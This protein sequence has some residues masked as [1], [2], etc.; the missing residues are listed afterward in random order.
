M[1][2]NRR[3]RAPFL[4]QQIKKLIQQIR[5]RSFIFRPR[6]QN[7]IH[8]QSLVPAASANKHSAPVA[9]DGSE[10][11]V[12][13]GQAT[14]NVILHP[15]ALFSILESFEHLPRSAFMGP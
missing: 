5:P 14:A 2:V 1:S 4:E 6:R 15:L 3:N 12:P 8:C 7:A 13:S 10:M 11:V 9:T